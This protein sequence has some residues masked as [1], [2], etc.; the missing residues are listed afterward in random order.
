MG[1]L[2]CHLY[3]S[4]VTTR[5]GLDWMIEFIAFIDSTCNYKQYSAIA[6]L[7]TFQFTVTHPLEF[8][9]FTRRILAKD[10]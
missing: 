1:K 7:P 6:D 10:S 2:Y 3:F 9:V 4:G 8:S 5:R